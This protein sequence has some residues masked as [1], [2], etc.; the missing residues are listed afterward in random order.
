MKKHRTAEFR[1]KIDI[2]RNAVQV[3]D[4]NPVDNWVDVVVGLKAVHETAV[5]KQSF[6]AGRVE[7][8]QI[9]IFYFRSPGQGTEILA[10][11]RVV[12]YNSYVGKIYYSDI[13]AVY[14]P[15]SPRREEWSVRVEELV[16]K[17][18]C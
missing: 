15:N 13:I 9:N 17:G 1:H 16:L 18:N 11:M 12:F 4:G 3:V 8:R 2:Q 14:I 7:D 10:G 5:S 6:E